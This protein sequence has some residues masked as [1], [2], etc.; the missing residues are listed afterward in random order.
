MHPRNIVIKPNW[1]KHCEHPEFPI[2]ALVTSSRLID[3]CIQACLKKY[4]G[5]EKITVGD[6][7]LQTCDWDALMRQ[8]GVDA[9]IE[10]YRGRTGPVIRFLD[11]RRERWRPAVDFWSATHSTKA[12]RSDTPR[13]SSTT[14]VCL[15]KSATTRICSAS[16]TTIPPR[17]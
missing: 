1:V 3:E 16:R 11:L 8:S 12:I 17:R 5:L 13:W 9:L 7:P 15:R 6:I 14:T 4:R 2:E 10:K